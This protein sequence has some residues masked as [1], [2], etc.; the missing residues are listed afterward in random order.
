MIDVED[1]FMEFQ[2][3]FM[4]VCSDIRSSNMMTFPVITS[5]LLYKRLDLAK[6]NVNIDEISK[7]SDQ[8]LEKLYK[9][10]CEQNEEREKIL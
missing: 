2:K 9:E 1:E 3:R 5:S 6:L 7:D 8:C 4:E 10:Y